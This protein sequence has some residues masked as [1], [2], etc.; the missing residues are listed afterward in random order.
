MYT[1]KELI[2]CTVT[3][4][5]TGSTWKIIGLYSAGKFQIEKVSGFSVGSRPGKKVPYS[6]K[7]LTQGIEK[8]SIEIV[9]TFEIET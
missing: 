7:D 1:A 4:V 2:G 5:S 3:W 6:I 9:Q 8:G